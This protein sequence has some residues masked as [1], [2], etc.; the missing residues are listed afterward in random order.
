MQIRVEK[1]Q[2]NAGWTTL[3]FW[4]SW[5][6]PMACGVI[7]YGTLR[8]TLARVAV[9]AHR[10]GCKKRRFWELANSNLGRE[11]FVSVSHDSVLLIR[12]ACSL[13][14]K[15]RGCHVWS[16]GVGI[17]C[18]ANRLVC[19]CLICWG[20]TLHSSIE[21]RRVS[22]SFG[23]PLKSGKA[24]ALQFFFWTP[25]LANVVKWVASFS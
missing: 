5:V 7:W 6:S 19:Y 22:G 14:D 23:P 4:R 2:R 21:L 13:Q 12:Y 10:I 17:F 15:P 1:S 3:L 18:L 20:F 24:V 8:S 9:L 25:S 16:P 11:K